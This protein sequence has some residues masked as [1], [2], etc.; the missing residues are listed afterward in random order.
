MTFVALPELEAARAGDPRALERLLAR[1]QPNVRRYAEKSCLWT[2][3]DDAVQETLWILSRHVTR[4]RHVAAFSSWLLAV[5]RREC[6]RLARRALGL[7]LWDDAR[8]DA[9]V[10]ERS[11]VV[12]RLEVAA[13]LESLPREYREILVLRDFEGL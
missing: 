8:V 5:V 10:A 9:W 12:Q 11:S 1:C 13:S 4:L 7:E 3:V 6:R 2:H